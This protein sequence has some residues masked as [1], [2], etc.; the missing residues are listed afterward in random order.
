[1]FKTLVG[2]VGLL[3]LL[4]AGLYSV[5]AQDKAP[6]GPPALRPRE[7]LEPPTA[8]VP[9]MIL[10]KPPSQ[11]VDEM[12]QR[13]AEI[14]E[15]RRQL[16]RQE[17]QLVDQLRTKMKQHTDRLKALGYDLVP[18]PAGPPPQPADDPPQPANTPLPIPVP[19]RPG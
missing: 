7:T 10:S 19:D 3:A 2:S 18:Q 6:P 8:P 15:Q 11:S 9:E 12:L 13:L 14:K 5:S 1:M 4:M 16:E 17:E